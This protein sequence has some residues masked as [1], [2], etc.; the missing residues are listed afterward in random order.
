MINEKMIGLKNSLRIILD[1][2]EDKADVVYIDY[3]LHHNVGDLLIFVGTIEFFKKY[4]VKVR[5]N[6]NAHN[7]DILKLNKLI[8]SKTTILCHGGGNFGD[9]YGLHHNLREKIIESFPN[10]RII[11][12]PQT[13]FFAEQVNLEKSRQIFL[14]HNN[15][16]LLARDDPTYELFKSFSPHTYLI[17]DMAHQLYETLPID[18]KAGIGT[19]YF[20]RKDIELNPLQEE[21]RNKIKTANIYDWEDL[22]TKKDH[23]LLIIMYKFMRANKRLKLDFID[24]A[25]FNIWHKHSKKLAYKYAKLFSSYDE[26]I[27]SRLHAHILSCLVGTS[28]TVIDNNYGKNKAYYDRWTNDMDFTHFLDE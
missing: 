25:V 8:T 20:F 4:K 13:A 12:L 17:P 6:L 19:F 16:V 24:D 26:V 14:K 21:L 23:K 22:L 11:I 9:I 1:F 18:K 28:S 2:I 10:N 5:K 7:L 27:T 15:V 3:P